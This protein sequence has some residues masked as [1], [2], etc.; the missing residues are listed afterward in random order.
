MTDKSSVSVCVVVLITAALS[1]YT[2]LGVRWWD[3]RKIRIS[4]LNQW[5][6]ILLSW[7]VVA[8]VIV[9]PLFAVIFSIE[10][11]KSVSGV[12]IGPHGTFGLLLGWVMPTG[13]YI[14]M[15]FIRKRRSKC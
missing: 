2:L 5:I 9:A 3:A 7:A 8:L 10:K 14:L 6:Q 12:D 15:H 13:V 11:L 4:V 1:V